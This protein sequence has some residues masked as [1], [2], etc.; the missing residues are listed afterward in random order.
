MKRRT[1]WHLEGRGKKPSEYEIATTRLLYH[2]ERGFEVALPFEAWWKEHHAA[3]S[4]ADWERFADPA[5][6][7]YA[8]YVRTRREREIFCL[9]LMDRVER[10]GSDA[11]LGADWI[12][13]ADEIFSPLRYPVHALSMAHAY[14]GQLAPSGRI[15]AVCAFSVGDEMRRV[16]RIAY[17]MRLYARARPGFGDRSRVLWERDER[18]QPLRRAI[19][20]LLVTYGWGE[21][22]VATTFALEPSIDELV[23]VGLARAAAKH[24][25]HALAQMLGSFEEDAR[26]RRTWAASLVRTI[27]GESAENAAR[28]AEWAARWRP[29]AEGAVAPLAAAIGEEL[30]HEAIWRELDRSSAP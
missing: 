10:D 12:A 21:A 14:L 1:Y 5:E 26:W 17:R 24:G 9:G 4:V 13:T 15:A 2:P 23:N 20:T 16:Q 6:T 19:E 7:T 29:I 25:D 3:L 18:W 8:R 11:G 22:L 30:S 27:R 28:I